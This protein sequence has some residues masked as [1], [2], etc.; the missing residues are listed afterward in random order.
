MW[1][2]NTSKISHFKIT[3]EKEQGFSPSFKRHRKGAKAKNPTK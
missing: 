1:A 2:T 3:A